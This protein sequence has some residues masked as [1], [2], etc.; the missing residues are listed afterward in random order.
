MIEG[1]DSVLSALGEM[2]DG[3]MLADIKAG[4]EEAALLIRD[5]ARALCPVQSGDLR[6][7][8]TSGAEVVGSG[9]Q[10][11]VTV[12]EEYGIYV[13]MGTGPK[14]E[15]SHAGISPDAHPTYSPKG[16]SYP[17]GKGGFIHTRGQAAQPFLY[18]AAKSMKEA[19]MAK[20]LA[21]V[22]GA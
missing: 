15:A 8:I 12:G 17:D 18:P 16:W 10:G 4:V 21:A 20:I 2:E 13:E 1:L 22:K 9:V 5:E 19:A 11:H 3:Q 14:G 7:S 6:R